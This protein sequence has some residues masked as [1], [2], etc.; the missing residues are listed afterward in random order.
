MAST[1]NY[2]THLLKF[3]SWKMGKPMEEISSLFPNGIPD[4]E[5][6]LSITAIDITKYFNKYTYNNE[7]PLPAEK[8]TKRSST[9]FFMKKAISY[10][11]PRRTQPWDP[12][13]CVGNPTKSS[14]VNE[15][16]KRVKIFEV[17]REGVESSARR[18]FENSEFLS[19]LC[20]N[21]KGGLNDRQE[22]VSYLCHALWCWQYQLIARLDDMTNLKLSE[23]KPNI[24]HP[25]AL[26]IQMVWSKN[27]H[28]ER[29]AVNQI[30]LGSMDYCMCP[31]IA[32][33]MYF[34]VHLSMHRNKSH[35]GYV[36]SL[37]GG[38]NG[39]NV[40]SKDCV[41]NR[42]NLCL[43]ASDFAN[44]NQTSKLGSHSIRKAAAT[45]ARRCNVTK[46]N[47]EGRGRWK[48]DS[49]KK[50]STV[51]MD[52]FQPFPD[53][54]VASTLCGVGGCCKYIVQDEHNNDNFLRAVVPGLFDY[55][56][57]SIARVLTAALLWFATTETP[58]AWNLPHQIHK[59]INDLCQNESNI[60][61]RVPVI[62]GGEG[63]RLVFYE[64]DHDTSGNQV[65]CNG[66]DRSTEQSR[67]VIELQ[68]E[69][70]SLK[71]RVED[72]HKI[73]SE[74]LDISLSNVRSEMGKIRRGIDRLG[75][76]RRV[77]PDEFGGNGCQ[78]PMNAQSERAATVVKNA[79]LSRRPNDL[80]TLWKEYHEGLDGSK[81]ARSFTP[82][83]RGQCKQQFYF[84]N[85]FWSLVEDL[86]RRGDTFQVAIDRIYNIYGCNKSVTSIIREIKKDRAKIFRA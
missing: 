9:L 10:F 74:Q 25:F 15:M 50:A 69:I 36:F 22:E 80:Y 40:I 8:P 43:A 77:T 2:T 1:N 86:I 5:V 14:E 60:V 55:I 31:L 72:L 64:N 71:R 62:V 82:R 47:V 3:M 84:R 53:A 51:Y 18:P 29:D 13:Q 49:K 11:M 34:A 41:R 37:G 12:I 46:D 76:M 38:N 44:V 68:F 66:S 79:T 45:Y 28:E 83:E 63:D 42:L 56:D 78:A 75:M 61:R 35:D 30:I 17:R 52:L 23:I 19:L 39:C 54:L 57:H 32:M 27:I 85:I 26:S 6:L 81:S 70:R 16:I 67:R 21:L 7:I 33:G 24:H 48:T 73:S 58:T 4:Q 20:V 65:I 59:H